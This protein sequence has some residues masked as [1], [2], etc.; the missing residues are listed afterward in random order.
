MQKEKVL[1]LIL[2][3]NF[4]NQDS[5]TIERIINNKPQIINKKYGKTIRNTGRRAAHFAAG[6]AAL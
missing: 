6:T 2:I 5:G 3:T 4:Q 1:K